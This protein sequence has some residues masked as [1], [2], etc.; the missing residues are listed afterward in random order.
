MKKIRNLKKQLKISEEMK[1]HSKQKEKNHEAVTKLAS[2]SNNQKCANENYRNLAQNRILNQFD[3]I[4]EVIPTC[5][6]IK[7]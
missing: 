2:F 5:T 1:P 6:K 4:F 3:V 7:L